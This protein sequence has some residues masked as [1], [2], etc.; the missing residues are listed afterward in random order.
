MGKKGQVPA[1]T[2]SKRH[3]SSAWIQEALKGTKHSP[4]LAPISPKANDAALRVVQSLS[5]RASW[6]LEI[7]LDKALCDRAPPA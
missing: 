3:D 6:M 5:L 1:I 2:L 4:P 7:P